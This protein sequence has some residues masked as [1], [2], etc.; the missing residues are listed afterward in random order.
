MLGF[1][2]V[3]GVAALTLVAAAPTQGSGLRE[4]VP[5]AASYDYVGMAGSSSKH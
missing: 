5:G 3:Y 1:A 2:C 4:G